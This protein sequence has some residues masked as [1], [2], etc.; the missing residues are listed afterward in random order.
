MTYEFDGYKPVVDEG[1]YLH[2]QCAV[3][4][5]VVIGREVYVGPFASIRGDWGAIIIEDGCNIQENCTVHMFPGVTVY[6]REGAH[7]GH[8]AI[9]HGAE[10]GRNSLIGM[11][12]VVMD[13]AVIGEESILGALAFVKAGMVIPRRSLVVGQPARVIG[14]VSDEML[15]WK[16]EGTAMYRSLPAIC[17]D[18]LKPCEPLREVPAERRAQIRSYDRWRKS[19]G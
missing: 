8:G 13:E 9:V 12:A 4:G 5:N 18:R 6:L 16:T 1:S 2:P 7:I 19:Q 14:E 15:A 3:T 11:N 17:R 10:I